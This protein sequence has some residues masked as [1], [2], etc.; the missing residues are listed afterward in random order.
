MALAQTPRHQSQF[1]D[2]V[3]PFGSIGVLDDPDPF[4]L[5]TLK[6]KCIA[7]HMHSVM[8]R[9]VFQRP[10]MAEQGAILRKL[11]QLV[12]AGEVRSTLTRRLGRASATALIQAHRD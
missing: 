3:Q 12:D 2:L 9:P 8:G 7:V 6:T 11:A 4:P 5:A 1:V 10:D